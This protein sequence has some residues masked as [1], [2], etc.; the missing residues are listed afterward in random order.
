MPVAD[1]LCSGHSGDLF[2]N[3]QPPYL[4]LVFLDFYFLCSNSSHFIPYLCYSIRLFNAK[5]AKVYAEI[6]KHL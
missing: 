1:D 3:H 5:A 6:A 4:F 2:P